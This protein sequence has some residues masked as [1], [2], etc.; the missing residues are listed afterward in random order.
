MLTAHKEGFLPNGY[1]EEYIEIPFPQI[2]SNEQIDYVD[3]AFKTTM[4]GDSYPSTVAIVGDT[5]TMSLIREYGSFDIERTI[6]GE[7]SVIRNYVKS[8]GLLFKAFTGGDIDVSFT[9]DISV[10]TKEDIEELDPDKTYTPTEMVDEFKEI[11]SLAIPSEVLDVSGDCSYRFA[12]AN[13]VIANKFSNKINTHDISSTGY[14]FQSY[15]Y[16]SIDFDINIIDGVA[17]GYIFNQAM[18]LTNP[19]KLNGASGGCGYMFSACYRLREFPEGYWTDRFFAR[20]HAGGNF[21]WSRMFNACYSLRRLPEELIRNM[22]S[23]TASTTSSY[24]NTN[25]VFYNCYALDE[26]VNYPV[27]KNSSNYTSSIM[28]SF[29]GNNYHLQRFTF[30]LGEDGQPQAWKAKGQTLDLSIGIGCN[31]ATNDNSV[32]TNYNSGIST[33]KNV[34]MTSNGALLSTIDEVAARYQELKNDPD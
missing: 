16:S 9:L 3:I 27:Q 31:T 5:S 4:N 32:L 7:D 10:H 29:V 22:W 12:F 15:P 30:A 21:E 13:S 11:A 28:N 2:T 20:A 1:K 23:I 6:L 18:Y 33:N 26:I 8:T 25:A 14:M 17:T 19:P 24:S 34:C